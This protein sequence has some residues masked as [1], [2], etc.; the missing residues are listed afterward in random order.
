MRRQSKMS[1]NRVPLTGLAVHSL[2]I[3]IQEEPHV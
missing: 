1:P 2:V 3:K